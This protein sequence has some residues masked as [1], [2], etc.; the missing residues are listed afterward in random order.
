MILLIITVAGTA[1][2][3]GRT[4]TALGLALAAGAAGHEAVVIDGDKQLGHFADQATTTM[5]AQAVFDER[6]APP[7]RV[8]PM[9]VEDT[10]R[11]VTDRAPSERVSII[12]PTVTHQTPLFQH[13]D[14]VVVP[15]ASDDFRTVRDLL[16]LRFRMVT[17]EV[18]T[19][20]YVL[21]HSVNR[22]DQTRLGRD[23][24]AVLEDEPVTVL[25]TQVP[26]STRFFRAM[27]SHVQVEDWLALGEAFAP[28]WT[29]LSRRI[30]TSTA[31]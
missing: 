24:Q 31:R 4:T 30:A 10:E 1:G 18:G 29:E 21:V 26:Y 7:L 3:T 27:G 20:L 5:L 6:T 11:W 13:S 19:P 2:G 14:A 12:D 8:L 28:V 23:V 16:P 25:D 17:E 15:M 9:T 22:H